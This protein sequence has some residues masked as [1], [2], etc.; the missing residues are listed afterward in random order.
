MGKTEGAPN[1]SSS[2]P[3]NYGAKEEVLAFLSRDPVITAKVIED[4]VT[5]HEVD[6]G[7]AT[8][9]STLSYKGHLAI[10]TH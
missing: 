5:F 10:Y 9:Y 2:I 1:D 7:Q 4:L 6:A 8:A 3:P